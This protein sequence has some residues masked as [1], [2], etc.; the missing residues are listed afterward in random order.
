MASRSGRRAGG[1]RP[2]D[3][4]TVLLCCAYCKKPAAR[5]QITWANTFVAKVRRSE[6][7]K[8]RAPWEDAVQRPRASDYRL[9]CTR[10]TCASSYVL[11]R[12]S[13]EQMLV[14]TA[15]AG[16]RR[17]VLPKEAVFGSRVPRTFSRRAVRDEAVV[18][19]AA[20]T[21]PPARAPEPGVS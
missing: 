6:V 13:L 15:R 12:E 19:V 16:L 2:G 20:A 3:R 1:P 11:E 21:R 4:R 9:R 8:P 14:R 10:S 7:A 5:F 18:T 17:A